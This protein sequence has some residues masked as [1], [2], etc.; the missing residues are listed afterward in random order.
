MR[1]GS[2]VPGST[3]VLRK[4]GYFGVIDGWDPL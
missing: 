4:W 3:V 2:E 1:L